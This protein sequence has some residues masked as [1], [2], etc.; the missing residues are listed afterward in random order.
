MKKTLTLLLSLTLLLCSFASFA[1]ADGP[2]EITVW[3]LYGESDVPTQPH[4]YYTQ[5]AEKFNAENPDI[6]VTVVGGKGATDIL[7][8]ISSGTTPDI[9]MN[10]WNN[11]PQWAN[12]GAIYNLTDFINNDAAWDK[13]DI[14]DA[15]WSIC[16]Y[17]KNLYSIP[18][19]FSS[20]FMFYRTDILK[21]CG[22]D[23]FP[24]NTEELLQCITDTTKADANGDIERLGMLPN[25]PWF[26]AV[27]WTM[28]FNAQLIAEDG[29]TLTANS[30]EMVAALTFVKDI[31]NMY[32][33]DFGWDRLAIDDFG[34]TV[35]GNRSTVND[36]VLSGEVAMRWNSEGVMAPLSE[37]GKDI[38]WEM[39]WIPSPASEN[40][41]KNGM[42]TSNV[43]EMNAKTANPEVAWKVL[44]SLTSKETQQ[45]FAQGEYGNGAF[46]ARRSTIEYILNTLADQLGAA[47]ED[48]AVGAKLTAN[49][50]F[51]ADAMLNGNLRAFPMVSYVNEYITAIGEAATA[52]FNDNADPQQALDAAVTKVQDIATQ[53]PYDPFTK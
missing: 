34:D 5:W 47:K 40:G 7:T 11:A 33:K 48:T 14:P 46:Y 10:F 51:V 13:N 16:Y 12:A 20:T 43:W 22:W 53:N 36:P 2:T 31:Y 1:Q 30:P 28:A 18:N 41:A 15:A 44:S 25:M 3:H 21:E 29:L 49:L 17:D 4:G 9:F 39:A 42:F 45:V 27:M 19:S 8:A 6:H 37:F 24:A 32:E 50:K 52:I 26:D 23:H 38:A 35:R